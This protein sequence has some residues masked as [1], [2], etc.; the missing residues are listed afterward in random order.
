MM[1]RYHRQRILPEIGSKGQTRLE[2]A[3][4][5]IVGVGALG[6]VIADVLARAGVGRLTLIDRDVVELTNL[7]RQTLYE[8]AD[9]EAG[10]PKAEA[11]RRKIAR[12]N[13]TIHVA[14]LVEDFNAGN[15]LRLLGVDRGEGPAVIVD[16]LDNFEARY[17]MNDVAVSEGIGYVYG[18]AVGT[19]GMTAS[20]L[21]HGSPGA[22]WS[23]EQATPCLRCV[24]P[25]APP[26]GSM[27]TCDTAGVL[28]AL[29]V[30]VGALEA[31]EA[32]K[33][34]TEDFGAVSRDLIS[35]ELWNRGGIEVRKMSMAGAW[36]Q[37]E[38]ACCGK[39]EFSHLRAEANIDAAGAVSLCGRNAVQVQPGGTGQARIDLAVVAERLRAA[40]QGGK[41]MHSPMML[42]AEVSEG[43]VTYEITL[44]GSGRAIIKGTNDPARGRALYARYIGL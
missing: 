28:G 27:P 21:P 44:F 19:S 35:L 32:I 10:V 23:E 4:V 39:K 33:I 7:Q 31:A 36:R 37:G 3:H 41:V 15:A 29:T 8:E 26:V 34:V 38:C 16:G 22:A 6:T 18:G 40:A 42:R 20:F 13:S 5:A 2:Q 25:E 24:F 1:D 9:A 11:A 14:A 12:V 30:T 17:L 43:G